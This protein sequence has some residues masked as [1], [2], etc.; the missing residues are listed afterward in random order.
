MNCGGA[1]NMIMN[2]YR[3][4]NQKDIQFDFLCCTNDFKTADYDQEIELLGGH[5]YKIALPSIFKIFNHIK[6]LKKVI[7]ENGPYDAIHIH[8]LLHAGIVSYVAKKCGIKNIIVHSHSTN[9]GKNFSPYRFFY[10]F[11]SKQLIRHNATKM[12][13]CGVEAGNFLF[14]KKNVKSGKVLIL[15]NAIDTEKFISVNMKKVLSIKKNWNISDDDIVIGQVGRL[16]SVKNH[17][18]SIKLLKE[19][20]KYNK[21]IK[22]FIV[23]DGIMEKELKQIVNEEQLDQNVFFTGLQQNINEWMSVFDCL[24]MPSLYEGIPLTLIEA[25][26]NDLPC[27]V[28]SNIDHSVDLGLNLI[29]FIDINDLYAWIDKLKSIKKRKKI[30]SFQYRKK[31]LENNHYDISHNIEVLKSIYCLG[32]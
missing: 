25:Q 11:I 15:S 30:N 12:I 10:E 21:N 1:E 7:C 24:I 19:L 5:I 27:F 23:G 18:F 16:T 31:V 32:G 2:L 20:I 6:D 26:A 8:T 9:Q 29:K 28:S 22:L 4:L 3:N 14:G 13:A 17:I